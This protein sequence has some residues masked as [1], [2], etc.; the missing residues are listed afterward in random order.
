[1]RL[2]VK[3]GHTGLGG[4]REGGREGGEAGGRWQVAEATPQAVLQYKQVGGSGTGILYCGRLATTG[5]STQTTAPP[6][7]YATITA[8]DSS[9][10]HLLMPYFNNSGLQIPDPRFQNIRH[11]TFAAAAAATAA[12][13]RTPLMVGGIDALHC[14][15]DTWAPQSASHIRLNDDS[16]KPRKQNYHRATR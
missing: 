15:E 12:A 16:G 14:S 13:A 2:E 1:M 7:P 9:T 4:G 8:V 5:N 3:F 6:H 10:T 11:S